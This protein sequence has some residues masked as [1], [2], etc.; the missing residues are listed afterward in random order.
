[1][2]RPLLVCLML[3]VLVGAP[4]AAR[5][6]TLSP[7]QVLSHPP[8]LYPEGHAEAARVELTLTVDTTG[9][10]ASVEVSSSGGPDFDK[11]AAEA[12]RRWTFHPALRDGQPVPARIRVPFVFAPP[13]TPPP[14]LSGVEAPAP[15]G[16]TPAL[17]A[18][19]APVPPPA[20]PDSGTAASPSEVTV[21]GRRHV[22]SRGAADY[23]IQTAQLATVPR[24]NAADFLKLAPG[25]LLTNESG[26]GHAEQVFLRG[27]DAREGQDLEFSVDG[28]PIN[29]SGNLHGNGYADTHFLIPELVESLRVLEG[30]FDP[31]QGNYAVA[32]SAQYQ[33]GL[34][35]RGL[36]AK[37]STGSFGTRRVLLAYGPPGETS[38]TFAAVQ[39]HQTDGFG[40]N[41]DGRDAAAIAQYEGR[42]GTNL[43]RLTAQGYT[44][45]FHT[46]GVLREDDYASGKVGFYDTYDPLQGEDG[47]R[48]SLSA[49]LTSHAGRTTF[50]NQVFAIYRP[51]RLREDFT[52]FLLDV[53]EPQQTPHDQRG[54]L[55]DTRLSETTFGARGAAKLSGTWRGL[56]QELELGYFARHDVV[57][58]L[59]QRVETSTGH[60]YHTDAQLHSDLDDL[61]LYLDMNLR[62]LRWLSLRGGARADLFTFSVN[63]LCA[64]SSVARP[65]PTHPES[66]QSCLTQQGFGDHREPNQL[67]TTSSTA[68]LP[69]AA[70]IVGPLHGVTL[71]ASAGK[72][73]RSIDPSYITQDRA[74]PFASVN[75]YEV[76]AS[77]AR[78]FAGARLVA[79]TAVFDTRVDKDLIFSQTAGRNTL[80]GPTQRLGSA[81][82]LRVTA[83]TFDV[84]LNATYVRATFNDTH[85][86]IPYVPDLVLRGDGS[87]FHDLPWDALRLDGAPLRATLAAGVTFVGARPLPYGTRSD[88]ILTVDTNLV[89]GW[90]LVSVGLSV[91]NLL[92]TQYRLGEYNY[93]SDFHSQAQPTLVPVRHFTAG[94]PRTLLFTLT[95]NYGGST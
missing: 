92:N 31:R 59:E 80:A 50:E 70:L 42:V 15:D 61:G 3:G 39:L 36:L 57:D 12:A 34:S 24:A 45:S 68:F 35:E 49:A 55:I 79:S 87:L 66:D 7:P 32:G 60:P 33:L 38:H 53:Q 18:L 86:L 63:N 5:A 84:S 88:R 90:P 41:R 11:A 58:A 21:L 51:L 19:P 30:P 28:V 40:Q 65:S 46:A 9:A 85:L 54:D 17:E 82:A 23:Q 4:R 6:Q 95:L 47:A 69:R 14:S 25:F 81:S 13:I 62:L 83:R 20:T 22:A 89:L 43:Y 75:A 37:L 48:Y 10:V 16:G 77:F 67:A 52:G 93:A 71:S 74:T 29:E 26:E 76:G 8:A 1:M 64:V 2:T 78:T 72:G 94:A 56:A 44:A 27:F 91:Q 73:V